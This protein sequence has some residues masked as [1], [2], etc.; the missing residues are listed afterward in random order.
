M[1]LSYENLSD[2]EIKTD[3]MTNSK[4]T[5]IKDNTILH[6]I[7]NSQIDKM[8][9]LELSPSQ[10]DQR[11]QLDQKDTTRDA[12]KDTTKDETTKLIT[13]SLKIIDDIRSEPVKT[14][15]KNELDKDFSWP[16]LSV[17]DIN[18][19]F[20][21]I[22]DLSEGAKLKIVDDTYLAEDKAYIS[23]FA[24][25]TGGQSRERIMSFLDHLF[26]E[27]K[28]NH[29]K[30]ISEIRTGIDVDNKTPELRDL[31][32]NM[33]IFLH[34]YDVMRNVYKSDTG[35]HAKLGVIRNKFFTFKESFFKDL[36][37]PKY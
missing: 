32:G 7:T 14:T 22:G 9:N 12:T 31:F 25:Y 21:V 5:D 11:D 6:S 3:Y 36:C 26:N 37:V 15:L 20:K 13:S 23:S 27:T 30:L 18:T 35:T 17:G 1:P 33:I 2:I 10:R 34:R 28:R 24:R 29:E 16:Q 19:S 4:K 8:D